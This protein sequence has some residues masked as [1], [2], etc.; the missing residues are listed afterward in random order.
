MAGA[1]LE[2]LLYCAA[3]LRKVEALIN[4][5]CCFTKFNVLVYV[6]LGFHNFFRLLRFDRFFLKAIQV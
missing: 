6:Y 1:V 4:V 3:L 5:Y 2:S